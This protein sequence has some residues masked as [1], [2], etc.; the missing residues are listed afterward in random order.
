MPQWEIRVRGKVQ[1]VGFRA[2]VERV[3]NPLGITG[4][5]WNTRLGDVEIIAS[6]PEVTSLQE[7][8]AALHEGPGRVGVISHR[9]SVILAEHVNFEIVSD[10]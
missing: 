5:V 6:H 3:A 7:F 10:R 2:Y 8:E 9:E 1:G 4:E